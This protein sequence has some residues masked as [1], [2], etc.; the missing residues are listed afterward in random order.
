MRKHAMTARL[1]CVDTT[2]FHASFI[3]AGGCSTCKHKFKRPVFFVE[4]QMMVDCIFT[5]ENEVLRNA[6]SADPAVLWPLPKL[7]RWTSPWMQRSLPSCCRSFCKAS[8]ATAFPHP[9]QAAE[10]RRKNRGE[11]SPF[12]NKKKQHTKIH[13]EKFPSF[14]FKLDQI[15]VTRFTFSSASRLALRKSSMSPSDSLCKTAEGFPLSSH[16]QRCEF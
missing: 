9:R 1:R 16:E 13:S 8:F 3:D 11:F 2:F 5:L 6:P 14:S 10:K 7:S 15:C 4:N 12:L